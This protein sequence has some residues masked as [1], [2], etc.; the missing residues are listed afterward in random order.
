MNLFNVLPVRKLLILHP[1]L[2]EIIVLTALL[3]S[4]WMEIF[5]VIGKRVVEE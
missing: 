3:L 5:L 2:V 1:K 4:M